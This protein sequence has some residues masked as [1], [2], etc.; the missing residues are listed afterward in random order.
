MPGAAFGAN[1]R[2][3]EAELFMLGFGWGS[4]AD[5]GTAG[6]TRRCLTG[7]AF[8][9]YRLDETERKGP[10]NSRS[11]CVGPRGG[12]TLSFSTGLVALAS[13]VQTVLEVGVCVK[14]VGGGSR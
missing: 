12:R 5:R 6:A 7:F 4:F 8:L 13:S 14:P 2:A 3:A 9:S 10:R 11:A 1:T